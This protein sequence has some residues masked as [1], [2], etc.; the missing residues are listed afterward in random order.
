MRYTK[1]YNKQKEHKKKG[2]IFR[3]SMKKRIVEEYKY[4]I[5]IKRTRN[6][7]K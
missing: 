1:N 5:Y 3:E 7:W 2:K 6:L 4:N